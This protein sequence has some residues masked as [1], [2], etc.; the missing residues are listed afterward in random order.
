MDL[1]PATG[2]RGLPDEDPLA[3]VAAASELG[4][5]FFEAGCLAAAAVFVDLVAAV[6]DFESVV[7]FAVVSFLAGLVCCFT[8]V[9]DFLAGVEDFD[10][11]VDLVGLLIDRLA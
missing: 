4:E 11:E 6:A 7:T 2:A 5:F 9:A 10:E 3:L 1:L 8:G